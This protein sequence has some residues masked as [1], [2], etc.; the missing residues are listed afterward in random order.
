MTSMSAKRRRL[1]GLLIAIAVI[2]GSAAYVSLRLT[3]IGREG[4]AG[5]AYMP[6]VKSSS[7]KA[8]PSFGGFRPGMV[9]MVYPSGPAERAGVERLS[10]IVSIDGI[11]ISRM[12]PLNALAEKLHAGDV[13]V[14]RTANG[15]VVRDHPVRFDSPLHVPMVIVILA[16]TAIVAMTFLLI[17][18]F[19]FWRL[20]T[21]SRAM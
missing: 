20:P 1:A 21:D 6:D 3:Q 9:Y 8:A 5:L 15:R 13:V 11:P 4:W 2:G 14:Y 7:G 10:R 18:T 16:T 17:G 19:V 12:K